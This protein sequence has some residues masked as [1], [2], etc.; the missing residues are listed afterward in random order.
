MLLTQQTCGGQR[1]IIAGGSKRRVLP[2][3]CDI[4][5]RYMFLIPLCRG[6]WHHWHDLGV[7]ITSVPSNRTPPRNTEFQFKKGAWSCN[8]DILICYMFL[9]SLCK[10]EWDH[11]LGVFITSVPSNRMPPRNTEYDIFF[12]K[13]SVWPCNVSAHRIPRTLLSSGSLTTLFSF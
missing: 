7:S 13:K 9:I 10:R 2:F 11:D 1:S 5:I 6:E 4:R 8:I 12:L 3:N